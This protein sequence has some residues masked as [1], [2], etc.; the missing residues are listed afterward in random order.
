MSEPLLKEFLE[1][2][3]NKDKLQAWM[4]NEKSL[5]TIQ[6]LVSVLSAE[7]VPELLK[8]QSLSVDHFKNE[9]KA[10]RDVYSTG[11]GEAVSG[12]YCKLVKLFVEILISDALKAPDMIDLYSEIGE[13]ILSRQGEAAEECSAEE[14]KECDQILQ[15][16]FADAPKY[17]DEHVNAWKEKLLQ[18]AEDWVKPGLETSAKIRVCNTHYIYYGKFVNKALNQMADKENNHEL[19]TEA[20]SDKKQEESSDSPCLVGSTGITDGDDNEEPTNDQEQGSSD[21]Q[22][23]VESSGMA[24]D[25]PSA[26]STMPIDEPSGDQQ[27]IKALAQNLKDFLASCAKLASLYGWFT[28]QESLETIG[29]M[30]YCLSEEQVKQLIEKFK[31]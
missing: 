14:M 5:E 20:P 19:S 22:G 17:G 15:R 29:V 24:D 3:D 2:F 21:P 26:D 12:A 23:P 31:T 13:L 7:D 18:I 10:Q 1:S 16:L 11:Q 27:G 6:L 8:K 9:I 25:E 28:R 30:F 4:V